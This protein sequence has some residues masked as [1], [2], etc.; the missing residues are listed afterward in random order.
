MKIFAYSFSFFVIA[1]SFCFAAKDDQRNEFSNRKRRVLAVQYFDLGSWQTWNFKDRKNKK[2]DKKALDTY[3]LSFAKSL[4]QERITTVILSFAQVCD[5]EKMCAD[6]FANLSEKSALGMLHINVH[7]WKVQ[8]KS[9][10]YYMV[11]FLR[12]EGLQVGLAFG[13]GVAQ[14][15]DW[16]FDFKKYRPALLAQNLARWAKKVGL[17]FF[18]FD[19]E[20]EFFMKNEVR[21]LQIFF[22]S[23]KNAYRGE[24][25]FSLMGNTV[26]WGIRSTF[27]D[28]FFR[29]VPIQSM[30]TGLNLMFY[31]AK[32]FYIN[33]GQKPLED[34]DLCLWLKDLKRN[35]KLPYHEVAK[36]INIGF[37]TSISYKDPKS[38]F[39]PLPYSNMPKG[40]SSGKAAKF[41]HQSME[42]TLSKITMQKI[43]FG[44]PFF[45]TGS[46][47][48]RVS[49]DLEF[50][51]QFS[52]SSQNF[53]KDYLLYQQ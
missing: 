28:P 18:D 17:S 48:Y 24:I 33:C 46:A 29:D 15:K 8:N 36:F 26:D 37:N 20:N 52:T 16:K 38:S 49:K 21:N 3:L 42:E 4:K 25:T 11:S 5:I 41:I 23:L 12:K 9:L 50:R 44:T 51:S 22:T 43:E 45:W 13:G 39:G 19:V 35:M 31:S 34:W 27:L 7:G 2:I 47:D 53:V 6:D 40:L 1:L 30:F 32:H 14:E 10:F